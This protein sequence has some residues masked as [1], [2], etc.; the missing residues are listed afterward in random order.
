MQVPLS[1]LQSLLGQES[2]RGE[3]ADV[4]HSHPSDL[5]R[6]VS[7][8]LLVDSSNLEQDF[9]DLPE[10]L[11]IGHVRGG[12]MLSV[13]PVM[14][15]LAVPVVVLI[16]VM[17][18]LVQAI[19]VVSAMSFDLRTMSRKVFMVSVS[20]LRVSP[21]SET[22]GRLHQPNAA[23]PQALQAIMMARAA[24]LN[25]HQFVQLLQGGRCLLVQGNRG[26]LNSS[27][28]GL[29]LTKF[30][31]VRDVERFGNAGDFLQVGRKL[32]RVLADV[33]GQDDIVGDTQSSDQAS[34]RRQSGQQISL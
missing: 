4:R 7:C 31:L 8:E 23:S 3:S 11:G 5:P 6:F 22:K 27:D 1:I 2:D 21:L 29:Q 13:L 15:V 24:R 18:V 9:A 32:G 33:E 19:T 12:V 20:F 14:S 26:V 34:W 28:T 30:E 16:L 25:R 10:L 17:L